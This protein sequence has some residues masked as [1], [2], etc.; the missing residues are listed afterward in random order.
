M[1]LGPRRSQVAQHVF[2]R[3]L[4]PAPLL[5]DRGVGAVHVAVMHP[6]LGILLLVGY[7]LAL[8]PSCHGEPPSRFERQ[9]HAAQ[10]IGRS[11]A[12]SQAPAAA[13]WMTPVQ[14][15]VRPM[16]MKMGHGNL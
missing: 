9:R 5:E 8:E 14:V 3:Q 10:S 12:A 11:T 1:G 2:P 15:S 4:E 6:R 7:R 16:S 13:L